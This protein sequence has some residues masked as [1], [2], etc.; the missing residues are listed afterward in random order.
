MTVDDG[1]GGTKRRAHAAGNANSV[2]VSRANARA[3]K[4]EQKLPIPNEEGIPKLVLLHFSQRRRLA[5]S[6]TS[7]N[8][9]LEIQAGRSSDCELAPNMSHPRHASR[10][11]MALLTPHGAHG[12]GRRRILAAV[13]DGFS[14]REPTA[15]T[16]SRALTIIRRKAATA[17]NTF[18]R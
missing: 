7:L 4:V 3:G 6:T 18:K 17:K 16:R 11:P 15:G 1:G 13:E 12:V 14:A 10:H 9:D 2:Q 8:Q 5:S